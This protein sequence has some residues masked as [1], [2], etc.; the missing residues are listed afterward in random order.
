MSV[1][2]SASSAATPAAGSTAGQVTTPTATV[3][4]GP[5]PPG[6]PVNSANSGLTQLQLLNRALLGWE[7]KNHRRPQSFAEFASTA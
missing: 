2:N 1:S 6:I 7:M 5:P 4:S 3:P